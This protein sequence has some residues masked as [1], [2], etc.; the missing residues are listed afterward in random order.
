MNN[1]FEEIINICKIPINEITNELKVIMVGN[2]IIY[3]SNFKKIIEY[4]SNKISLKTKHSNYDI[5]G[6]ELVIAQ[7]NK[8]ELVIKGNINACGVNLNYENKK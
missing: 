5:V 1:Y 8:S 6:N 7:I 4:G 2:R 3:I